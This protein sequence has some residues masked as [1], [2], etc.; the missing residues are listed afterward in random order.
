MRIIVSSIIRETSSGL[1]PRTEVYDTSDTSMRS[2]RN[3]AILHTPSLLRTTSGLAMNTKLSRLLGLPPLIIAGMTPTTCDPA[4]V[5]A[6]MQAGYH[7]EFAGGGYRNALQMTKAL[8]SVRDTMPVGRKIAINIIYID[9]KSIAWQIPMIKQL[10]SAGFPIGSITIG[11]GVPSLH[12]ATEYIADLGLDFISFKPGSIEAIRNVLE[13]ARLHANFPIVLQW[14]SGRGGG[15]HSFE[16]FNQPIL[17]TYAEIRQCEN[18]VLVAGSGF[19]SA[20]DMFPYISGAWSLESG[21]AAPMP[22]DGI[23]L[24]SRMMTCKEAPTSSEVK[25]CISAAK[26]V[27]ATDWEGTIQGPHGGII[28][29]KSEMG[30]AIHVVATRGVM[31]WAEMDRTVFSLDKSKQAAIINPK[32]EYIIERLNKDFQKVWFGE[33]TVEPNVTKACGLEEMTYEQVLRRMISLMFLEKR[34]RWIDPSYWSIYRDFQVRTEERHAPLDATTSLVTDM[35]SC[36]S[37]SDLIEAVLVAYPTVSETLLTSE[38]MDYFV[39]ICLRPGQKPVPFVPVLDS[40][41]F[42]KFFKKDSL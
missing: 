20:E 22:F 7:I 33:K 34:R 19:G 2:D 35:N 13:I 17:D 18:V 9:Q 28:S 31:F 42:E 25:K 27:E 36:S 6:T 16:D 8:E 4:F 3:W 30:E 12:V 5:S 26:G 14:T 1:G 10:R 23:L 37:P 41:N 32:R 24:G 39:Q 11:A 21:K 15:H 38:D 29:V 40:S